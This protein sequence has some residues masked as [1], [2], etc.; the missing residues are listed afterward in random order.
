MCIYNE[1][2]TL[3]QELTPTLYGNISQ[4]LSIDYISGTVRDPFQ[5]YLI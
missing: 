4:Y 3:W 2:L 5:N 1:E